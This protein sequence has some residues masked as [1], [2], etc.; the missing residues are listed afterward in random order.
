MRGGVRRV[1]R[2]AGFNTV[3]TPRGHWPC[4]ADPSQ[5]FLDR[6]EKACLGR[7]GESKPQTISNIL[8]AFRHL[9]LPVSLA[10]LDAY[11]ERIASAPPGLDPRHLAN[12][13]YAFSGLGYKPGLQALNRMERLV[14]EQAENFLGVEI[15][16]LLVSFSVL[17][18]HRAI[19]TIAW[20]ICL[21]T[22][23]LC[24]ARRLLR[25]S[26]LLGSITAPKKS[27]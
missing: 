2:S 19:P 4:R 24:T 1:S 9:K 26:V 16:M 3:C 11:A 17:E 7:L 23:S 27:F 20:R 14:E 8:W 21:I 18:Q 10:L 22:A 5:G 12:V 25:L 6:F 13:L 15:N